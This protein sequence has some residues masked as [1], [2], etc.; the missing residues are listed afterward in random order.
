MRAKGHGVMNLNEQAICPTPAA[1]TGNGGPHGLGGG[2]AA[3]RKLDAMGCKEMGTGK[4]NPHW[5]AALMGYPPLWAEIGRRF[6]KESGERQR[7][8][9]TRT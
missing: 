7:Q 8:R 4:L 3:N 6:N 2:Q 9:T 5:V 1:D